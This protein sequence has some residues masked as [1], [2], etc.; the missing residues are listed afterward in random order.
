MH[1]T[2][3]ATDSPPNQVFTLPLRPATHQPKGTHSSQPLP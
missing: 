3:R 2:E 1:A